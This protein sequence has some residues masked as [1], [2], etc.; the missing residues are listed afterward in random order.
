MGTTIC[1]ITLSSPRIATG[2]FL[3]ATIWRR[4]YLR[5]I[6]PEP[7]EVLAQA[8]GCFTAGRVV[9]DWVAEVNETPV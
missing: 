3:L 1:A 7:L 2:S 6:K 5:P 8:V 9:Q 4:R